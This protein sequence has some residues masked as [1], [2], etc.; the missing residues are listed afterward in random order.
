MQF[1][2]GV[3]AKI[4]LSLSHPTRLPINQMKSKRNL[5]RF[6][7]ETTA[8]QGW[9]LCVSKG[10][11]TFLKYFPDKKYGGGRK[12]MQVA[13]NALAAVKA[14][15]DSAKKVDGKLAPATVK[16]VQKILADA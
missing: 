8:F 16:K 13:E 4:S 12:S 5:T 7:Y 3:P 2:G 9:R 6:T 14:V 11:S 15:L 1:L 10:G